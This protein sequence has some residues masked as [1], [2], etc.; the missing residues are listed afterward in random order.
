MLLLLLLLSLLFTVSR[1]I[2]WCRDLRVI[3]LQ[4]F[5]LATSAL[6]SSSLLLAITMA[7]T[8]VI[9]FL[10]FLFFLAGIFAICI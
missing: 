6:P 9:F 10:F 8:G 3:S 5:L 2:I 1:P 7:L 4:L